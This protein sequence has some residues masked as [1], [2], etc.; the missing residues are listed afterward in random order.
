[1]IPAKMVAVSVLMIARNAAKTIGNAIRSL[2]R[3]TFTD[4]E[5]IAFDDG[6]TDSTLE[7]MNAFKAE[8]KRIRVFTTSPSAGIPTA[9]N[10]TVKLAKG[11]ILATLDA[12][13]AYAP[14]YL[15]VMSNRLLVG[16]YDALY[17]DIEV[18]DKEMMTKTGEWNYPVFD[19]DAVVREMAEQGCARIPHG[20]MVIRRASFPESSILYDASY[21]VASDFERTVRML[22]HSRR[23]QLHAQPLYKMRYD[24]DSSSRKDRI[25][26]NTAC[27]R[28]VRKICE[29]FKPP[30]RWEDCID[31]LA[32]HERIHHGN[33]TARPWEKALLASPRWKTDYHLKR[34]A[35]HVP[36]RYMKVMVAADSHSVHTKRYVTWLCD[37]GHEVNL[38]DFQGVEAGD[39]RARIFEAHPLQNIPPHLQND[40]EGT[41]CHYFGWVSVQLGAICAGEGLDVLHGHYLTNQG[42]AAY[43]SGFRPLVLTAWGSDIYLDP[44]G[45]RTESRKRYLRYAF[46]DAEAYTGDSPDLVKACDAICGEE[47]GVYV[48]W[49]VDTDRFRPDADT[50][51]AAVL[52]GVD[53]ATTS[54]FWSPRQ[55]KEQAR[56]MLI[57]AGYR[58]FLDRKMG[59]KP[60][61]LLVLSTTHTKDSMEHARVAATAKNSLPEGSY[62]LFEEGLPEEIMP[63]MA[64]LADAYLSMRTTDSNSCSMMECMAAGCYIVAAGIPSLKEWQE[65]PDWTLTSDPPTPGEI[66]DGLRNARK[67]VANRKIAIAKAGMHHWLKFLRIYRQAAWKWRRAKGE[68]AQLAVKAAMERDGPKAYTGTAAEL[69]GKLHALMSCHS[70]AANLTGYM[71]NVDPWHITAGSFPPEKSLT[72]TTRLA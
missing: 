6:S 69:S 52:L 55:W 45:P 61:A 16:G 72:I 23:F 40:Q 10:A 22:Q 39:R 51:P 3:Q 26:R 60:N 48:P 8:D 68:D 63:S 2:Q 4:W 21:P 33:K 34:V 13:D 57:I 47:R 18:Y 36:G 25:A 46:R 5:L 65:Q 15:D 50:K 19:F 38:F 30:V 41:Y 62:R 66:A 56:V 14:E 31:S 9:R 32:K 12:D 24:P 17:C 28:V 44:E 58:R 35:L 64:A 54:V 1:M 53:P 11:G 59:T 71:G 37:Q 27:A 49:A 7:S 20:S 43:L 29:T 67:S 42:M 70:R